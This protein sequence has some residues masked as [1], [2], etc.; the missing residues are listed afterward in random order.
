MHRFIPGLLALLAAAAPLAADPVAT[1]YLLTDHWGGAV[2]DAEKSPAVPT[3]DALCWAAAASNVL[4][5]TGWG[6]VEGMTT[7]DAIFAYFQGHWIAGGGSPNNAWQWWFDDDQPWAPYV[8]HSPGGGFWPGVDFDDCYR[9]EGGIATAMANLDAMLHEG[10]AVAATLFNTDGYSP[11]V[12]T[13]WGYSTDPASGGYAGLWITDSDDH[14]HLLDPPD[15]LRYVPVE[16]DAGRWHLRD[17]YGMD[18]YYLST[19]HGLSAIPE[20]ATAALL[21]AGG[22]LPALSRRR[23]RA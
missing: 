6:R 22:M 2:S 1:R 9:L 18:S 12:I 23:G 19:L 7:A 11:H 14:Q 3:D 10:R 16:M 13:V 21:A 20:P 4:A 8:I 15:W 5:W 17:Y